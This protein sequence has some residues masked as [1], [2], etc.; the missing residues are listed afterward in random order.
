MTGPAPR[1]DPDD[2]QAA[3][4]AGLFD[5]ETAERFRALIERR[6]AT[7]LADE[8]NFRLLTG[9]N[10]I[11]VVIALGMVL[12]ALA[13]LG[14]RETVWLGG[15]LVAA[16]SWALAEFFTRR[17]RMAL[18]SLVLLLTFV[19]GVVVCADAVLMSV[20][21]NANEGA[22]ILGVGALGVASAGLHWLRFKVPITVA[23]GA[24]AG[25][26]A[27]LLAMQTWLQFDPRSNIALME[28]CG[29]A[30]FAL[31]LWWD[32]SDTRRQT[33]RSDVAF[34]LHLLAAPLIVHPLF[35]WL[36]IGGPMASLWL[37]PTASA[38][39]PALSTAALALAIYVGLGAVALLIDRRALMVSSLAYFLYAMSHLLRATGAL[40]LSLALA[41]LAVGSALLL[42]S[43]FWSPARRVVLHLAPAGLRARLPAG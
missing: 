32:A 37:G 18:P 14:G 1:A 23:A 2:I 33:R 19:S 28:L 5:S 35:A 17:R 4:E 34:W 41:A 7:P 38:A 21:A 24:L 16:A 3:V 30:V 42:L 40:S 36:G 25:V 12:L 39:E 27:F 8:E 13:W 10:D 15:A 43:A 20:S 31:A 22:L 9:F 11:F 26:G 6:R 29:L